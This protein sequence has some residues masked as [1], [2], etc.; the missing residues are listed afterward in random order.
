MT[1]HWLIFNDG[2]LEICLAQRRFGTSWPVFDICAV[3][4]V[5]EAMEQDESS[6]LGDSMSVQGFRSSLGGGGRA[7]RSSAKKSRR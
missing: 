2:A 1:A 5:A 6:F 3:Q 7:A 4:A